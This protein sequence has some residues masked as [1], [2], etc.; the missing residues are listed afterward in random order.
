MSKPTTMNDLFGNDND[1]Y[2]NLND[3]FSEDK[4]ENIRDLEKG[5]NINPD[6]KRTVYIKPS[7]AKTRIMKSGKSVTYGQTEEE[8]FEDTYDIRDIAVEY[9][10]GVIGYLSFGEMNNPD[11]N[12]QLKR[13]IQNKKLETEN[14]S[15]EAITK[16]T[17][18]YVNGEPRVDSEI[19]FP[20]KK[21]LDDFE[22]MLTERKRNSEQGLDANVLKQLPKKFQ[23]WEGPVPPR[24][25]VQ[26]YYKHQ[27]NI[28][29]KQSAIN[30]E[31]DYGWASMSDGVR[32]ANNLYNED[33]RLKSADA[34]NIKKDYDGLM[35]SLEGFKTNEDSKKIMQF[36]KNFANKD[37]RFNIPD[38]AEKVQLAD[39][40]FISKDEFDSTQNSLHSY[41][42]IK[43]ELLKSYDGIIERS[44][45][46]ND[47]NEELAI[48]KLNFSMADKLG[49]QFLDVGGGLLLGGMEYLEA[50]VNILRDIEGVSIPGGGTGFI[51]NQKEGN[52]FTYFKDKGQERRPRVEAERKKFRKDVE[53]DDAFSSLASTGRFL[54]E[55]SGRQL[56]IFAG[57]IATGGTAGLLGA[58]TYASAAVAGTV[59]GVQSG[60]QQVGDMT[61]QDAI[62]A[63][64]GWDYNNESHTDAMKFL[65]GTGFGL[66]E[67]A[68]GVAPTFIIG[69]TA[70]SGGMR[71]FLSGTSDDIAMVTGKEYFKKNIT[72][73]F[74]IGS[75]GESVTEGLTSVFQNLFTGRPIMENVDHAMFAGGFFGGIM[76]GGGVA[77][78][79]VAR[80]MANKEVVMEV[81]ENAQN[82]RALV[83]EYNQL[84]DQGLYTSVSLNSEKGKRAVEIRKEIKALQDST[85]DIINDFS[86]TWS[87]KMGY[88]VYEDY[89]SIVGNMYDLRAQAIAT[90]ART[91]ISKEQIQKIIDG[92]ALKYKSNQSIL[93]EFK[94]TDKYGNRFTLLKGVDPDRHARILKEAK[95]NLEF[96]DKN[97]SES[98]LLKEAELI[99]N[100]E[101]VNATKKNISKV[102]KQTSINYEQDIFATEAD[103]IKRAKEEVFALEKIGIGNLTEDQK[104]KLTYWK[105]IR[106]AK[107]GARNGI[108]GRVEG[109]YRYA[110]IEENEIKNS[111][112]GTKTHE[113]SHLIFWDK[114]LGNFE[115]KQ[116]QLQEA[117]AKDIIKYLEINQ[118]RIY[119]EMFG[120]DM[121]QRVESENG[122]FIP[123]EI[124]AGFIERVS[125]MDLSRPQDKGFAGTIGRFISDMTGINR[126]MYSKPND[127]IDFLITLG[128][129]IE[130]GTL[131]KNDLKQKRI[132]D[133]F[134]K[135]DLKG[136]G[137]EPVTERRLRRG[138][139]S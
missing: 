52:E 79:A 32:K 83:K 127:V 93:N 91:D 39:G 70:L 28:L 131:T 129:K 139:G 63:K 80:N 97:T 89:K 62:N 132:L 18:Y 120:K 47:A 37:Y 66:A 92:F 17:T 38:G 54:F 112:T 48:S 30:S 9:D 117:I 111:R 85:A 13:K 102:I 82:Q 25:L 69:K 75:G 96:D 3:L 107:K 88:N 57:M 87:A 136:K 22:K 121:K 81:L 115:G 29:D 125:K 137:K 128:Q 46:A 99:Y 109:V 4:D 42:T 77:M 41:N 58:G 90:K 44:D 100:Q 76:S 119:A 2:P 21:E 138:S 126:D 55:E 98:A 71:A 50:G 65:V 116:D 6:R 134:S 72:K 123:K 68:L 36:E 124:I 59:I 11:V 133:L 94:S 27:K 53:F 40:R 114:I 14:L 45:I 26:E 104:T 60:G 31:I 1:D 118:P 106:D 16:D 61:Y 8:T 5:R 51:Y 64:D 67:G 23:K 135:Y 43:D 34:K 12:P 86:D 33:V 78:G 49:F 110:T 24:E 74:L 20:F 95:T 7:Q 84:K 130:N 15:F 101:E 105:S 122:G 56:P 113:V 73:E 103:A 10:D 19:I 108:A 35:I